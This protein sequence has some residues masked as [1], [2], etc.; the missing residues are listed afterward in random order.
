MTDP[1]DTAGFPE[2][3]GSAALPVRARRPLF[4][5]VVW[6]M[7]LLAVAATFAVPILY[8]PIEN[9]SLWIIWGIALLGFL[10]LAAGIAAA[11]RRVR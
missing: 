2:G 9:P 5:T 1:I 4:S 7:I 11:V 10:L 3:A 8:D 6:G